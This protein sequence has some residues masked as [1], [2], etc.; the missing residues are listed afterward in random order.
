MTIFCFYV[1]IVNQFMVHPI[2]GF[3]FSLRDLNLE[4]SL[5]VKPSRKKLS[6]FLHNLHYI[7]QTCPKQGKGVTRLF[8]IIL[9][10]VKY[11]L[12]T[13]LHLFFKKYLKQIGLCIGQEIFFLMC[14]LILFFYLIRYGGNIFETGVACATHFGLVSQVGRIN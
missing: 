1:Y 7:D 11:K 13:T 12:V 5:S 14:I 6:M 9:T 8:N 4:M 3:Y 2:S 10:F